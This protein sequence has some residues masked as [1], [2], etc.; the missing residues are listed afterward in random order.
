MPFLTLGDQTK[1]STPLIMPFNLTK[2][3][4]V[5]SMININQNYQLIAGTSEAL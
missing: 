4:S 2:E 1:N 5:I 3:Q